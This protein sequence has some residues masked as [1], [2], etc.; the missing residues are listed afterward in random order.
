MLLRTLQTAIFIAILIA[1]QTAPPLSSPL[2]PNPSNDTLVK[3]SGLVIATSIVMLGAV[4]IVDQVDKIVSKAGQCAKET[5]VEV[6]DKAA[7]S[8]EKIALLSKAGSAE[9]AA[10]LKKTEKMAH[11]AALGSA[12]GATDALKSRW[13]VLWPW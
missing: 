10:T 9:E 12:N 6:A 5:A 3:V 2:Q 11:A 7:Q 4:K 8:A 1:S 13:W